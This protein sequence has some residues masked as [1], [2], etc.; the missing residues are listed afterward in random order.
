MISSSAP[1][2]SPIY[3]GVLVRVNPQTS[4][5]NTDPMS[6]GFIDV[7]HHSAHSVIAHSTQPLISIP[8]KIALLGLSHLAKYFFPASYHRS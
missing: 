6:A 1:F 4:S 2:P 5:R 3:I 7:V 8:S